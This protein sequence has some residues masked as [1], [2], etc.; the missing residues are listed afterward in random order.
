MLRIFL[1]WIIILVVALVLVFVGGYLMFDRILPFAEPLWQQ[2]RP[3]GTIRLHGRVF[4][5]LFIAMT[6]ALAVILRG[7]SMLLDRLLF[8]RRFAKRK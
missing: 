4:A 3:D 8:P 1:K 2:K 6:F 5:G 7:V